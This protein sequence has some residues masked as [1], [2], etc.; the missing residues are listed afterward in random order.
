MTTIQS[1]VPVRDP[2]TRVARWKRILAMVAPIVG[3]VLGAAMAVQ[4]ALGG[5]EDFSEGPP[6]ADTIG[7]W[8]A[9]HLSLMAESGGPLWVWRGPFFVSLALIAPLV[10]DVTARVASRAARW[11]TRGGLLVATAAIALEYST[12]GYGWL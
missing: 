7:R 10:W 4:W 12:P 3:T 9:D 2:Q 8:M 1:R 11:S 6:G 5:S